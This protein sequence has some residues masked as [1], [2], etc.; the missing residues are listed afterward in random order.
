MGELPIAEVEFNMADYV[1]GEYNPVT[2][3]LKKSPENNMI[4]IDPNETYLS[5]G[6]KGTRANNSFIDKRSAINSLRS[7]GSRSALDTVSDN[8]TMNDRTNS[9]SSM[10][11]QEVERIKKENRLLQKE[12]QRETTIKNTKINNLITDVENLKTDLNLAASDKMKL[13]NQEES[14]EK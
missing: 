3:Y 12:L 1:Y 14:L 11:T 9:I 4:D 8:K 6:L 10:H 7:K 2:L 13:S 5:I